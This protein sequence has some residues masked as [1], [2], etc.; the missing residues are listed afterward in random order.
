VI[1]SG[2]GGPF[3][4]KS[5]EEF[6]SSC[7]CQRAIGVGSGAKALWLARLACG[8][9]TSDRAITVPN[10]L[11]APA[12][13]ITNAGALPAFVDGDGRTYTGPGRARSGDYFTFFAIQGR[14]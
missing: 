7:G 1:D 6:G 3:V 10:A 4:E 11:M 12:E 14:C 2:T 8:V 5:E 13:A 9:R